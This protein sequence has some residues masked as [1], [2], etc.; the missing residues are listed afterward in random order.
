MPLLASCQRRN[1]RVA[2]PGAARASAHPRWFI[3][4]LLALLL[5]LLA[6]CGSFVGEYRTTR[7]PADVAKLFVVHPAAASPGAE[8]VWIFEQGGPSHDISY[9]VLFPFLSLPG[10]EHI[11]LV[12]VHQTLTLNPH[13]AARH[14]SLSLAN[15][16]AEVDVSV[17]LLRRVID[18]FKARDKRVVV[19]GYSYGSFLVARYL[20]QHGPGGADRYLLMAGRLDMPREFVDGALAGMLY[21]FPDATD[22]EPSGRR[23]TTDEEAIELLIAGATFHDRYTDRLAGTDLRKAIYVYATADTVVGRLSDAEVRFL[24]HKGGTVIVGEGANH[25]SLVLDRNILD[26]IRDAL[27]EQP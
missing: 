10:H 14:A 6:G 17:E 8:T 13:L 26:R 18:H 3:P 21:H 24:E 1:C 23:P 2:R 5:L 20:A 7:L 22:P 25:V 19:V 9:D 4:A 11:H 12:Q 27:A 15:L 16:Q